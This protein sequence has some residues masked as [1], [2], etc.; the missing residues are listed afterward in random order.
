[1]PA[2]P[3]GHGVEHAHLRTVHS[4]LV[5]LAVADQ[6]FHEGGLAFTSAVEEV[7]ALDL[8][9]SI[10]GSSVSQTFQALYGWH[11]AGSRGASGRRC[12]L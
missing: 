10:E 8:R 7:C 3:I 11:C 6:R 9:E 5:L 4:I 1:M 2:S 12:R